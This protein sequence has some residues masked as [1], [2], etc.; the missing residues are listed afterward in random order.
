MTKFAFYHVTEI[1]QWAARRDQDF[2]KRSPAT[3]IFTTSL[4]SKGLNTSVRNHLSLTGA[5]VEKGKFMYGHL[6]RSLTIKK[7]IRKMIR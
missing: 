5:M 1:N 3:S 2:Q 7:I 4:Y 6:L